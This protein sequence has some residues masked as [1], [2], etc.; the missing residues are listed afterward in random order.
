[1]THSELLELEHLAVRHSAE[2]HRALPYLTDEEAQGHLAYLRRI[3]REAKE[4]L[5]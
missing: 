2:I 1:M 3:D 4:G 5:E